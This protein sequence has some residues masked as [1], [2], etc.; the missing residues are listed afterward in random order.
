VQ[1]LLSSVLS[2]NV[3]Q[4]AC[5]RSDNF[6]ANFAFERLNDELVYDG[7]NESSGPTTQ[8][9]FRLGNKFDFLV[10]RLIVY[11]PCFG[12]ILVETFIY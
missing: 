6:A 3:P 12:Y 2:E 9:Y 10:A 5:N 4:E 8:G 11:G 1:I 7:V